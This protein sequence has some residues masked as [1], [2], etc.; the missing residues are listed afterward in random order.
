M[1]I[2]PWRLG[3]AAAMAV[4][5]PLQGASA[6]DRHGGGYDG[7]WGGG[8]YGHWNGYSGGHHGGGCRD[9]GAALVGLAIGAIIGSAMIEASR[10]PVV[11]RSPTLPPPGRCASVV[12]DGETYYHC[13][14]GRRVDDDA[15]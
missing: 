15:W 11:M 2:K 9:C 14:G 7:R 1:K 5:V 12:V 3:M 4:L 8:G 6:W 13:D 10:P